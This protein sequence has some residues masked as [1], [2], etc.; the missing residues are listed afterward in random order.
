MVTKPLTAREDEAWRTFL[1]TSTRLLARLDDE[2]RAVHGEA[3]AT[4]D[5][6][7]NL[8]EA[9]E[10]QL[11]M[12]DLAD[13]TLFSRSRLTYTV[14]QLEA[15]GLVERRPD[16]LDGRGV[17]AALT[18]DGVA[19]H[20]E[21]ARTHLAGVRRYFIGPVSP[22]ALSALTASLGPMLTELQD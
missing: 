11:R 19:R 13:Q 10:K 18:P 15:R 21:L 9:P 16:E 12:S 20:R 6:L 2:M 7:S 4:F 3:I 8:A 14:Q 5:V 1:H 22:E 17:I